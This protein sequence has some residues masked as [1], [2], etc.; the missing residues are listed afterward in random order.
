MKIAMNS[1]VMEPSNGLSPWTTYHDRVGLMAAAEGQ[2][3]HT[4]QEIDSSEWK[5][6]FETI[7]KHLNV[8]LLER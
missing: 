3:I 8:A 4:P 7:E 2:K 6:W 5:I 1:V